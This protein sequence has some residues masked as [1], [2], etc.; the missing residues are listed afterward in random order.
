MPPT[1]D[2]STARSSFAKSALTLTLSL[3][4]AAAIVACQ[5]AVG[6]ASAQPAA[7]APAVAVATVQQTNVAP[8]ALF[9]MNSNFVE[10]RSRS[11]AKLLLQT[12]TAD[13]SRVSRAWYKVL[14]REPTSEE[15]KTSLQYVQRF[16]VKSSDDN[17]RLLAWSS[18]CRTLIASNDFIYIH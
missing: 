6:A 4:A 14:G 18:L 17:A 1:F 12:E 5:P 8:Q 9:M 2:R 11:L 7:A 13:E 10:E 16:P 3:A 15:S